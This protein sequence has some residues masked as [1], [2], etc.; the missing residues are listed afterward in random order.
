[1]EYSRQF[2][3]YVGWLVPWGDDIVLLTDSPTL[4]EPALRDLAD[5][6]IEGVV[7]ADPDRER[8]GD[9]DLPTR[10]LGRLPGRGA[11][12]GRGG[13]AQPGRVGAGPPARTPCTSLS[14]TSRCPASTLPSGELWVHCQSGYRAG[15]AASLLHRMGRDVVHVDDSWDRVSEL[16]IQTTPVAAA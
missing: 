12:T 6:G 9:R 7:R 15:I 8:P 2:A 13:R 10:R 16:A 5:I 14:R 3:T 1:M 11:A 4:L